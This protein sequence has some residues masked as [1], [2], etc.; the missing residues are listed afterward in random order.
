[1]KDL[2]P[3]YWLLKTVF[4]YVCHSVLGPRKVYEMMPY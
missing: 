2:I 4:L 3:Y 1:M